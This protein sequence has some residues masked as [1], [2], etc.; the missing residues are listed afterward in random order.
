MQLTTRIDSSYFCFKVET[1][2]D[3]YVAVTGLPQPNDQHASDM[4]R[5]ADACL[6]EFKEQTNLL[7]RT[8]GPDTAA[9][10]IRIGLHSG[11][12]TAG[13]LRGE[14]SRFQYVYRLHLADMM[15]I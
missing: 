14:R 15:E 10:G 2:G 1:I 5:F 12:V 11:P 13:V 9:L 6:R 7:E 8:L 4:A 3:S